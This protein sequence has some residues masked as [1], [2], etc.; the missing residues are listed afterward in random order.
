MI[1]GLLGYEPTR[2]FRSYGF[3][4]RRKSLARQHQTL[5]RYCP[6]GRIEQPMNGEPRWDVTRV[7]DGK[8]TFIPAPPRSC[9]VLYCTCKGQTKATQ[10][11]PGFTCTVQ[12]S[13]DHLSYSWLP[14][15]ENGSAR[16]LDAGRVMRTPGSIGTILLDADLRFGR[17]NT[18]SYTQSK[19]WFSPLIIIF[20][21]KKQAL[22]SLFRSN[23]PETSA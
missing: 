16:K 22:C 13:T 10:G 9:A 11:R 3:V 14:G 6:Q 8:D 5:R 4:S 2:Y 20:S 18:H 21:N 7:G 1:C 15:R 19:G 12:Y 17:L 23:T